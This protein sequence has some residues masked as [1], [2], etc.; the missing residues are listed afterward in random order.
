MESL[1]LFIAIIAFFVIALSLSNFLQRR[2]GNT[3]ERETPAP[4]IDLSNNNGG[5]CGAHEICEKDSLIATV[6]EPVEYFDDEELDKY[7]NRDSDR[8]NEK[9]VNEFRDVFYSVLDEEKPRWIR[10]LQRREIALPD[11]LKDEVLMIVN[12]LR[13]HKMHA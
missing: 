6:V 5:C 7:R 9:E 12:D 11:Q 13:A 3:T 1:Y 8:Y 10:S 4:P 2:K